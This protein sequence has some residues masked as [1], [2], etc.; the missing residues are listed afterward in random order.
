MHV[1][2]EDYRAGMKRGLSANT[3]PQPGKLSA[4]LINNS[5][6]EGQREGGGGR[7]R[8]EGQRDRGMDHEF[9]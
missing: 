3:D 8:E 9:T 1:K 2:Q 7:G 5:Y 4:L 6:L